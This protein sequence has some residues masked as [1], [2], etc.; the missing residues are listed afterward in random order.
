MFTDHEGDQVG[1]TAIKPKDAT[2]TNALYVVRA[3]PE[4]V[5]KFRHGRDAPFPL[6]FNPFLA[7]KPSQPD[8]GKAQLARQDHL[9]QTVHTPTARVLG[10]FCRV[11]DEPVQLLELAR[12]DVT[13]FTDGDVQLD[14]HDPDT[15]ELCYLI[16]QVLAHPTN[17]AVE[18]LRKDDSEPPLSQFLDETRVRDG[19]EH[20]NAPAHVLH[21][22]LA[23]RLV[24]RHHI[25]LFVVVLRAKDLVDDVAITGQEYQTIAVLVQ[26]PDGEDPLL[27]IDE[28][29]DGVLLS[30]RVLRRHDA[31]RL[32]E[33]NVDVPGLRFSN[34]SAVDFHFIVRADPGAH[35]RPF[36]IDGYPTLAQQLVRLP[37]GTEAGFAQV[38]VDANAVRIRVFFTFGRF[39]RN[40][41]LPWLGSFTRLGIFPWLEPVFW[42]GLP[43]HE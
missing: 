30:F 25:F 4:G 13:P 2:F 23:Q 35:F 29:D 24:H 43:S 12:R 7:P 9:P 28:L 34:A 16:A 39:P 40:G 37:P 8:A 3:L 17:L 33:G 10:R 26:A 6:L 32:V 20:G 21:E 15:T 27:V 36:A 11:R 42:S 18:T 14:V 5:G 1:G 41:L 22:S 31:N 19:A 38:F